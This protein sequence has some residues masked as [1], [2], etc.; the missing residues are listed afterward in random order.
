MGTMPEPFYF[1]CYSSLDLATA[2]KLADQLTAGPP[3]IAVWLDKR[4]IQPGIDWDLQ[5]AEALS[6]CAGVLYL[7]S[8]DSV[9]DNS[10]CQQE[11]KRALTYK[12]PIIPLLF[13]KSAKLPYRLAPRQYIDFTGDFEVGLA[14]LR[15]HL[16]WRGTDEGAL[17]ALKERLEDAK[18]DLKR[19]SGGEET[20]ILEEIGELKQQIERQQ[21]IIADPEAAKRRADESISSRIERE[22]AP[23]EPVAPKA[24]TKFINRLPMIPPLYFQDRHVETG[25]IGE[26]LKDESQRLM[27]VVGRGGVGKTAMV[28]RLLRALEAG[29][30]PDNGGDLPVD[31][32]VYLS[33]RIG[34][35]VNYPNLF[36]DLCSLLPEATAKALDQVY[37]N[38]KLGI[39]AQMQALLA[40]FPRGRTIVLL[41]NF[42]DV[43]DA[44]TQAIAEGGL[45]EALRA[46]I[47]APPHGVK[48]V[49]TTRVAPAG[50]AAPATVPAAG[51]RTGRGAR[52]AARRER[53]QGHGQ[54]RLPGPA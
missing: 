31:G 30:L 18:R 6:T 47:E 41:D 22:K 2:I 15:D 33:A 4:E 32:I 17:H 35:P 5:I 46:A 12:K 27:T 3:S 50:V 28:C 7:M 14:K 49:L 19:A 51:P 1:I 24:K 36:A 29:K 37:R 25:L 21:A 52:L 44:E 8:E 39:E 9:S 42:E 11:W 16:R 54:G 43:V 10:E 34:R 23:A 48:F 40:E 45:D 13:E 26:F 38:G 53:A 20:R